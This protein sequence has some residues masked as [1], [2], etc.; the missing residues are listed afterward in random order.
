MSRIGN[1]DD[2]APMKRF[3]APLKKEFIYQE[4]YKTM[5]QASS[6]IFE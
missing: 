6:S 4:H 2:K 5:T 3:F 1:G